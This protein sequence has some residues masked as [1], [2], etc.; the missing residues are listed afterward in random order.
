VSATI[1]QSTPA[2]I[3]RSALADAG[4]FANAGEARAW[5][6]DSARRQPQ[7]VT[8]IPFAQLERWG[9]EPATGDLVHSSGKFFRV[10]GVHVRRELGR[11]A[12]W[13]QPIVDQPEIGIL[14]IV[15]REIDG[16]LHLLM[17]AKLEPGNPLGVQLSP[18]VQATRSN[19]TQ[20]HQGNRP[21]YLDYFVEPGRGYVLV[22]ELQWE[23]GSAFLRK[24]NRNVVLLV[25]GHVPVEEGFAW[26]TLAQLKALLGEANLVSMDARTVIA[27]LSMV[28]GRRGEA[29]IEHEVARCSEFGAAVL[30][31]LA[32]L[33]AAST[34]E[35]LHAW[36]TWLKCNHH[37]NVRR[38]G[39]S[40]I[41]GWRRTDTEIVSD[42][43]SMFKIVAVDV[44]S[45]SREVTRWTQPMIAACAP[46]TI[47]F[48]VTE[49]GGVLHALLR[50]RSEPGTPD[51]VILGPTAQSALGFEP[52]GDE[53]IEMVLHPRSGARL[54]YAAA[55]SEEGGRFYQTVSEY[56][57]VELDHGED[58]AI[59]PDCRWL[60]FRQIQEMLRYGLI[61]VEARSLLSC[62]ALR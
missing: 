25:D 16:V 62:L 48:L 4:V 51:V 30:R 1:E 21:L 12:E 44:A 20:V 38:A 43:G 26:F 61:G 6:F 57:I 18:T 23:H 24:R 31:S 32:T 42:G 45:A 37:L 35:E 10:T 58:L 19:Y 60:T 8:S 22:D 13:E 46:G 55:Q 33:R 17:Q 49:I 41:K 39:L 3:L 59:S 11:P 28:D 5:I 9:F 29:A 52:D 50:A 7:R 2:G 27:C 53:A 36:L 47:G 56:R 34:D 54:R 15:A 14:G 40:G